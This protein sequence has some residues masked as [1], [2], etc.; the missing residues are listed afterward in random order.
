[1]LLTVLA[2]KLAAEGPAH[3]CHLKQHCEWLLAGDA[4]TCMADVTVRQHM[5]GKTSA[6]KVLLHNCVTACFKHQKSH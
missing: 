5:L 6:P 4:C 1:M 3:L 2:R